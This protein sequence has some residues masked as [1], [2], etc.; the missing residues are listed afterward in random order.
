MHNAKCRCGDLVIKCLST[1]VSRLLL[2]W[3]GCLVSGPA[4]SF[5][6]SNIACQSHFLSG[7]LLDMR[8]VVDMDA[9]PFNFPAPLPGSRRSYSRL[10]SCIFVVDWHCIGRPCEFRSITTDVK[11]QNV[12]EGFIGQQFILRCCQTMMMEGCDA[13]GSKTTKHNVC[14]RL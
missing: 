5:Q 8:V 9:S 14:L 13:T 11:P 12:T 7:I 10:D 6:K 3:Y 1:P 4:Q 2:L